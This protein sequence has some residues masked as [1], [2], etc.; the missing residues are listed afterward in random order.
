[1]LIQEIKCFIVVHCTIVLFFSGKRRCLG[2]ILAKNFI[3]LF[4]TGLLHHYTF[5]SI[6]GEPLPSGNPI[7]GITLSPEPFKVQMIPR[8]VCTVSQ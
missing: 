3:F 5:S 1:M 2:E 6:P 8:S 7:P 4:F